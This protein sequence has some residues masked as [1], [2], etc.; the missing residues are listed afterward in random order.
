[1]LAPLELSP[2]LPQELSQLPLP[3][4]GLLILILKPEEKFS[5]QIHAPLFSRDILI[6]K[7]LK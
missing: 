6:A 2:P 3:G 4:K 5:F 1:M 7:S